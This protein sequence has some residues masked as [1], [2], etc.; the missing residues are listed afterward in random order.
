MGCRYQRMLPR[1]DP[2]TECIT[3]LLEPIAPH[4]PCLSDNLDA[5]G[6]AKKDRILLSGEVYR[7]CLLSSNVTFQKNVILYIR[8]INRLVVFSMPKLS[9]FC[10]QGFC[11]T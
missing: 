2:P 3:N 5:Y 9:R 6:L 7:A 8:T 4:A 10:C 1:C 11:I